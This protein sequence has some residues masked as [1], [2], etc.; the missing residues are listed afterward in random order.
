MQIPSEHELTYKTIHWNALTRH[1]HI[2]GTFRL[3]AFLIL[4]EK[5]V[6]NLYLSWIYLSRHGSEMVIASGS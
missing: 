6:I 3:L 5:T 2:L 1:T 4:S